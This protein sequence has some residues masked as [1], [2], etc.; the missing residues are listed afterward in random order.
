MPEHRGGHRVQTPQSAAGR[1]ALQVLPVES[2]MA[3]EEPGQPSLR[4]ESNARD[5]HREAP[6]RNRCRKER[7]PRSSGS[8]RGRYS[9][10]PSR[11]GTRRSVRQARTELRAA[12]QGRKRANALLD[13][14]ATVE[15]V[16]LL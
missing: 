12:Q 10:P 1:S 4:T 13:D 7:V 11:L 5:V 2:S 8:D 3:Q 16:L 14:G 15:S 9:P 6:T